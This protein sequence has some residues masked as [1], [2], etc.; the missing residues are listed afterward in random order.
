MA[1]TK[2]TT[3]IMLVIVINAGMTRMGADGKIDRSRGFSLSI[4]YL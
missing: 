1:Y 2:Y 4:I 3:Y